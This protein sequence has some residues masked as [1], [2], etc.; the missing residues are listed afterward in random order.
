VAATW[1]LVGGASSLNELSGQL[2]EWRPDIVVAEAAMGPGALE[3][4][5]T[6]RPEARLVVVGEAKGADAVAGSL[7]DVRDAILGIP[8]PGGPVR[9]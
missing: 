9:A 3:R 2:L 4:I 1:E 5:R 6:V 7:E 8:K